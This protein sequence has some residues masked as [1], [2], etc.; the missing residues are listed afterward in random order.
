MRKVKL[1]EHLSKEQLETLYKK[2]KDARI[3]E[4][5]HAILLLYKKKMVKDIAEILGRSERSLNRWIKLWNNNGVEGLIPHFTGG[6]EPLL[7]LKEWKAVADEIKDKGMDLREVT[8]YVNTTKGVE[9]SY[10]TT[11][12]WLRQKL[13]ISYRK[14]YPRNDKRP[15]NAEELLKKNWKKHYQR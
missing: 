12:K 14:P 10:K 4:R 7:S 8:I 2:E 13:K 5:L 15:K 3:R 1:V 11:W 9:C 6:P